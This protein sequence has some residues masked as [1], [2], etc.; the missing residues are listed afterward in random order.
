LNQE[1]DFDDCMDEECID[2]NQA[3]RMN[4][5]DINRSYNGI[6][7]SNKKSIDNEEKL[8]ASRSPMAGDMPRLKEVTYMTPNKSNRSMMNTNNIP[9][10]TQVMIDIKLYKMIENCIKMECAGCRKLIPTH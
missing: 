5:L 7:M 1:C 9:N 2:A 10:S 8:R 6:M 3:Q 4:N